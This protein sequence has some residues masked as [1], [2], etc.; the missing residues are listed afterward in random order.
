MFFDT[1]TIKEEVIA[2]VTQNYKCCDWENRGEVVT[3][4]VED[5]I[6]VEAVTTLSDVTLTVRGNDI[7]IFTYNKSKKFRYIDYKSPSRLLM[8]IALHIERR[9]NECREIIEHT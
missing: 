2:F 5:I 7:G 6:T 4:F 9:V 8:R 3:L 1:M